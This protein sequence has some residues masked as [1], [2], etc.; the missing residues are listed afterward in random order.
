MDLLRT[1]NVSVFPFPWLPFPA[2]VILTY[3]SLHFAPEGNGSVLLT[4][5]PDAL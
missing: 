5:E 2:L 1:W 3:F 4:L